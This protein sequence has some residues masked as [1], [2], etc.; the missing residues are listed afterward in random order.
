MNDAGQS[1]STVAMDSA[2][3]RSCCCCGA[4]A[5]GAFEWVALSY[6]GFSGLLMIL[7][8]RRHLPRAGRLLEIH[9]SVVAA[10]FALV[11]SARLSL[12][13]NWGRG[14][15]GRILRVTRDWYPQAVFLFCFEELGALEQLI[16]RGWCDS[17]MM[18]FDRWLTGVNPTVWLQQICESDASQIS[19]RCRI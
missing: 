17:W 2:R 15:F 19:C 6:L 10:I 11:I 16:R 8:S 1:F 9:A 7:F 5:C 13:A 3:G 4:D 18:S 14:S 12:N